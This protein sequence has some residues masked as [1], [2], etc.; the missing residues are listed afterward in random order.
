LAK[1][2][3]PRKVPELD[4]WR[5]C[6]RSLATTGQL[7]TVHC[8]LLAD[9]ADHLFIG[10]IVG[11]SEEEVGILHF[12]PDAVWEKEPSTVKYGD[13]TYV[14]FG[15]RYSSDYAEYLKPMPII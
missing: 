8:D 7:I 13:I 15:D 12:D 9:E 2:K 3:P 1:V 6:M 10:P 14:E 5:V 11:V 4:S